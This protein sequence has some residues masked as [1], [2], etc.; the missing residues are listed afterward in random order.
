MNILMDVLIGQCC[1]WMV[2]WILR[3]SKVN[4]CDMIGKI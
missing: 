1:I 3:Y 2:E 4:W